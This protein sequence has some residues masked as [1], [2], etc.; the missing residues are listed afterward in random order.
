[1]KQ[2]HEIM[3]HTA[4][5]CV[6]ALICCAFWGSA[7]PCIKLGYQFFQIDSGDTA[8]QILFAGC[9]FAL[10]GVLTI[11]MG[12]VIS[13]QFLFPK[14]QSLPLVLK[15]SL[16]QTILQYLLFYI[17]LA[18]T[19]GVKSSIIVGTNVFVSIV[20]ASFVFHQE[21]MTVAKTFG[22]LIGFAGVV[23][24]NLNGNGL[25]MNMSWLG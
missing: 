9:R 24:V 16:F 23:I 19:T 1:M 12:S 20:V 6:G 17:G 11:L 18:H 2:K 25:D 4:V 3:T 22:C 15:L 5:V 14:K 7:F 13:R 10:S 21:K 8:A